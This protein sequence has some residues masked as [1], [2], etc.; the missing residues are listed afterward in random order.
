MK[1]NDSYIF[2]KGTNPNT[3]IVVSQKNK[4]YSVT[5]GNKAMSQVGV[6]SSFSTS[7][8]KSV[9]TARGIGYGDQIAENVPGVTGAISISVERHL[10]YL[11]NAHQQFGYKGGVDGLVR[12]LKHHQWPFDIKHEL[13][14]SALASKDADSN[15]PLSSDGHNKALITIY[16]ACWMTSLG[17]SYSADASIVTE[18]VSIIVSDVL[19]GIS[20]YGELAS[21]A[22]S[23][24]NSPFHD[25]SLG[26]IRFGTG[27]AA[28]GIGI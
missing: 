5:Y 9:D 8:D 2:R 19:D 3:H 1:D 11:S 15:L 17:A 12:S 16:E 23:T 25:A 10:L 7:E 4:V 27:T 21:L 22:D 24:G 18:S 20:T 14:M 26:S 28:P 13:V 6:M